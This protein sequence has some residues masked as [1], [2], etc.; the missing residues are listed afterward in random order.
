MSVDSF[1]EVRI[2]MLY[3]AGRLFQLIGLVI[4]PVAVAGNVAE[5]LDLR[6]SLTLSAIGVLIFFAGWL[7]QQGARR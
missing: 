1:S 7:L 3:R 6:Q 4:L 5:Q 2:L